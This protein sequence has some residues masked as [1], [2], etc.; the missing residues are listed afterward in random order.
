MLNWP[1]SPW[2]TRKAELYGMRTG[3][4]RTEACE[5]QNGAGPRLFDTFEDCAACEWDA[6]MPGNLY[7]LTWT[8]CS[9][10]R[11]HTWLMVDSEEVRVH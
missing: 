5:D 7:D 9:T 8:P 2:T 1:G 6:L 4:V 3:D 10:R 11:S